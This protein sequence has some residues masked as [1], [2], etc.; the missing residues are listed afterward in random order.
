MSCAIEDFEAFSLF[1]ITSFRQSGEEFCLLLLGTGLGEAI[2]IADALRAEVEKLEVHFE[3]QLLSVTA[4]FGV[5]ALWQH[6][7]VLKAADQ[8]LQQAK[9]LGRNRMRRALE[10]Q[11]WRRGWV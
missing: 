1:P 5:A 8:A 10:T 11:A 2:A 3:D 4:S 6:G 7:E 9:E